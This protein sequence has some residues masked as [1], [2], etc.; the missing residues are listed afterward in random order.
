M[1]IWLVDGVW[2]IPL[3]ASAAM[4]K[5]QL[6][7]RFQDH[8]GGSST[9]I[10][11]EE[12][13]LSIMQRVGSAKLGDLITERAIFF[14]SVCQLKLMTEGET[15]E[16]VIQTTGDDF[17]LR[18]VGSDEVEKLRKLRDYLLQSS[19]QQEGKN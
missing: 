5:Q 14:R 4:N 15:G 10:T 17:S 3:L 1:E 7:Y 11:I 8:G 2:E 12:S 9:V 18:A 16:L 6:D 13:Y 19:L